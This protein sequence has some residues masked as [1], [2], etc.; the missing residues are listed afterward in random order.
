MG[1]SSSV[2]KPHEWKGTRESTIHWIEFCWQRCRMFYQRR[3]SRK[4]I[5]IFFTWSTYCNRLTYNGTTAMGISKKSCSH[6]WWCSNMYIYICTK[7]YQD[8]IPW[9]CCCLGWNHAPKSKTIWAPR[10]WRPTSASLDTIWVSWNPRSL[11][12]QAS[13]IWDTIRNQCAKHVR[14]IHCETWRTCFDFL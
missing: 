10:Q 2:R 11:I 6:N 13:P 9:T 5:P 14:I 7:P 3:S 8:P 12:N 1:K 4:A